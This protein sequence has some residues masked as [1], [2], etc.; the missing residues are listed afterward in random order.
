MTRC[1]PCLRG[2]R[3]R[4][5]ERCTPE[6]GP[7]VAAFLG[8]VVV[9]L[10]GKRGAGGIVNAGCS[11]KRRVIAAFMVRHHMYLKEALT[12]LMMNVFKLTSLCILLVLTI[13]ATC[14]ATSIMS[15]A[16]D[17]NIE[18]STAVKS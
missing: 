8:P 9:L 14:A 3:C 16:I 1:G 5:F 18:P 12:R 13:Q 15:L 7:L 4:S 2:E 10:V 17:R 6:K 11:M